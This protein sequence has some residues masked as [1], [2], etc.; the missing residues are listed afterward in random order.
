MVKETPSEGCGV[1]STALS[2]SS[3]TCASQKAE[4]RR[5]KAEISNGFF[6]SAFC[7]LPLAFNTAHHDSSDVMALQCKE[8]DEHRQNGEHRAGHHQFSVLH[9]L[10]DEIGH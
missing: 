4:V 5:Q 7:F 6:T 2:K 10:A 3:R 9:V 1:Q 8:E